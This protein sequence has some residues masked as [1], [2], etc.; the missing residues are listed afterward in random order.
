MKDES[1]AVRREA[2]D[3]LRAIGAP[4]VEPLIATLQDES[5]DVRKE[6]ANLLR[7]IKDARAIEPLIVALKDKNAEVIKQAARALEGITGEDF[8]ENQDNWRAW[9]DQNRGSFF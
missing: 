4:A 7:W 8:D 1:S 3:T 2:T 6:A 9:W 5:P